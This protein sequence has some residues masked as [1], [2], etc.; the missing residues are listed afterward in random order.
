AVRDV[1]F[2]DP[3]I[4]VYSNVTGDLI[5]SGSEAQELCLRQ[6]ITTVMWTKEEESIL[7]D[8]PGRLL[9][10]G[11]GTVLSGL[12]KAFAKGR[13]DADAAVEPAGTLEQIQAIA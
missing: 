11:P 1:T 7:R 2:A 3:K 5:S 4:P 12:W 6:L 8:G 9:E 13:D 10:V